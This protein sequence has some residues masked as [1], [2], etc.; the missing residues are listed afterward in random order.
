MLI[1]NLQAMGDGRW[2]MG[3][4]RWA[5]RDSRLPIRDLNQQL[6]ISH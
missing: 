4:G 3:D 5:I 2:A 1:A 6:A